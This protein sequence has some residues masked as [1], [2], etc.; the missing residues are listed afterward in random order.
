MNSRNGTPI[1]RGRPRGGIA[2]GAPSSIARRTSPTRA[3]IQVNFDMSSESTDSDDIPM[4]ASISRGA[5]GKPVLLSSDISENDLISDDSD[6]SKNSYSTSGEKGNQISWASPASRNPGNVE[7]SN[8]SHITNNSNHVNN[9]SPAQ[10]QYVRRKKVVRKRSTSP[11]NQSL[12]PK[13][14]IRA[15]DDDFNDETESN[16][17]IV[18]VKVPLQQNEQ[19]VAQHLHAVHPP[20]RGPTHIIHPHLPPKH[21]QA[22][23]HVNENEN[24]LNDQNQQNVNENHANDENKVK[25]NDIVNHIPQNLPAPV[26]MHQ[27]IDDT[28]RFFS[29]FREIK[30]FSK[31]RKEELRMLENEKAIFFSTES[32]DH[33]GKFHIVGSSQPIVYGAPNYKGIVRVNPKNDKFLIISKDEIPHDDREGELCGVS[34]IQ[35]AMGKA[36]SKQMRICLTKDGSPHFAISKRLSLSTLAQNEE[37]VPDSQF[38]KFSSKAPQLDAK[39]KLMVDFGEVFVIPSHKNVLINNEKGEMIYALYKTSQGSYGVRCKYPITPYIAFGLSIAL[40]T[41]MK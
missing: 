18:V 9:S 24:H 36:K 6:S 2:R 41:T 33:I 40:V 4:I 34:L 19:P 11:R 32:K 28:V 20:G 26:Q 15:I 14:N 31:F 8:N 17:D 5:N 1:R 12:Q 35:I 39:G 7:K 13:Q 3:K 21:E 22:E 37:T 16:D 10:H 30:A 27:E 25:S 29:L 38:I 23:N